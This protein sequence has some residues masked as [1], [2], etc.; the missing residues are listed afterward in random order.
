M[1]FGS[2][3]R[4]RRPGF[5]LYFFFSSRRR[6]TRCSRDWSSDVCSPISDMG[7]I[8]AAWTWRTA[9]LVVTDPSNPTGM[10]LTASNRLRLEA[11]ARERGGWFI[12]D[13]TYLE[14]HSEARAAQPSMPVAN[15]IVIGSF[16]KSLSLSGWRVGYLIA[17]EPTVE[18][19][20]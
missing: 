18:G 12:V 17:A 6:H 7:A 5:R 14:F 13:E 3:C 9:G 2:A 16:S 1:R 19:L 4:A 10:N 11:M 15:A 8:E 20:L